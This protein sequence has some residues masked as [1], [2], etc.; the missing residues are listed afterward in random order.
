MDGLQQALGAGGYLTLWLATDLME[1][2]C[3][4]GWGQHVQVETAICQVPKSRA[5][6]MGTPS[7]GAEN[8]IVKGHVKWAP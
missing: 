5:L 3:F 6:L 1:G 2:E 7:P 8:D 4:L